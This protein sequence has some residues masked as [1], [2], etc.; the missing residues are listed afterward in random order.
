MTTAGWSGDRSV[1]VH[2]GEEVVS[3]NSVITYK[4]GNASDTVNKLYIPEDSFA[5]SGSNIPSNQSV[6]VSGDGISSSGNYGNNNNTITFNSDGTNSAKELTATDLAEG[7]ILT[8]TYS[9]RSNSGGGSGQHGSST[10]TNYVATTT[11]AAAASTTPDTIEF[12]QR[13]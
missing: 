13:Q 5:C 7:T 10:T 8:L 9:V 1:S 4:D 2:Y 3:G 6:T 11:A 12:T